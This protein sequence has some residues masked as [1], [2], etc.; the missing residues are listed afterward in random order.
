MW[1]KKMKLF[2]PNKEKFIKQAVLI[3]PSEETRNIR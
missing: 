3:T 1:T 2:S